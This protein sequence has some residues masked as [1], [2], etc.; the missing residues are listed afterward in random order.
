MN[1][2][3]T[4]ARD[5]RTAAAHE[6]G[7]VVIARWAG[8]SQAGANIWPSGEDADPVFD[9][10]WIGRAFLSRAQL[11]RLSRIRRRMIG[12]A[13]VVGEHVWNHGAADILDQIDLEDPD[14]MSP[15]DWDLAGCIPGEPDRALWQAA[16]RVGD[17]INQGA[18]P[19]WPAF[20]V[21]ARALILASREFTPARLAPDAP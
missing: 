17:L 12:V 2:R 20:V 14:S 1:A 3:R 8:V 5:R 13:G 16:A 10:S 9:K 4:Q 21:E 7:H 6:A 11:L 18:G 15:S 19:L